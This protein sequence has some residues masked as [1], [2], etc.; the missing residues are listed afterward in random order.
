MARGVNNLQVG[1]PA[2]CL[3]PSQIWRL[4][5][6]FLPVQIWT[7]HIPKNLEELHGIPKNPEE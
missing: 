2:Q 7:P 1:D 3:D 5:T 6:Y 4:V